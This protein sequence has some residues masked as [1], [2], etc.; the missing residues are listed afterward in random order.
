MSSIWLFIFILIVSIDF[1][2]TFLSKGYGL[3]LDNAYYRLNLRYGYSKVSFLK[4]VLVLLQIW[5]LIDPILIA[6]VQVATFF[7]YLLIVKYS[8]DFL[9]AIKHKKAQAPKT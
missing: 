4:I 3:V 7:Y 1:A 8:I 2:L 5:F 6:K 9:R